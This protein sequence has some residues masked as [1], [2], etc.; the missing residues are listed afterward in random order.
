M[1]IC[2]KCKAPLHEDGCPL[3]GKRKFAREAREE[4]EIYLTSSE[5]LWSRIVEDALAAEGIAFTRRGD[6][7]MGVSFAVGDLSE[8]YDYYV[9]YNDY[10]KAKAVLPKE[11]EEMSE[12][13]LNAYIDSLE[14]DTAEEE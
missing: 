8:T 2:S 7:G 9:M 3:C 14:E 11:C 6:L 10:E 4:D 12:E 13:E 1:Q 5:Y